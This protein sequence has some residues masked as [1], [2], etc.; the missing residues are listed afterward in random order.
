MSES[1]P[2][3][4]KDSPREDD[5]T[6]AVNPW[7]K[8]V[9]YLLALGLLALFFLPN[10][11]NNDDATD[12]PYQEFRTQVTSGQVEIAQFNNNTGKIS[13]QS[14][15]GD[16]FKTS[17][18]LELSSDDERLFLENIED[19][20]FF[21]PGS[22]IW[23]GFI[24]PVLGP[25]ALILLFFYWLNRRAQGQMG[26]IMSIGRSKAKA[27]TTERP[28]TTFDDVAG[29]QGV[30][31]EIQEVVDF[32]Q[33]SEKFAEIGA[34]IPKGVLLV[35]PPGTGK[36]LIARAVAGE[37]GVP[38]L[39]V[40]GSDFMEMFVGVGAS[41][42]RDLFQ[43]A[44]KMGSAIIF[45]DEIDSIGRKRGAGLGGGHDEREQ[46]LN[47]MLAEMDGFEATEG[48]VMMAATNR[49]DI[50]DPALLRPGRF[51]RQVIVSL[52]ELDDREQILEVHAKAKKMDEDVDLGLLARGTPGMSGAD[53]SNLINEAALI[54]V[55]GGDTRVH[56][57]HLEQA[58]DRVLMGQTRE[59]TVLNSHERERVAYHESGHALAA[60]LMPNADPLHK[61]SIIP[62]GMALGVT[63]TLPEEDRYLL[64]K[65]YV[66]DELVKML[67]G[68]VAED[69]VFGEVS[70]GAADDL[71]RATDMARKMV[72]EWGM[73]ER[74]GPMAW[75]SQE[76]VFLGEDMGRGRDYSDDMAN[77]ID[78]EIESILREA[79][80]RCHDLLNENR[81]GLDALAQSLLVKE[82]LDSN[83][84]HEL[85]GIPKT[86]RDYHKDL[87]PGETN[88]D[89]PALQN[90]SKS[91]N[92]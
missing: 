89:L 39:S 78:E 47:Q 2:P 3:A 8:R 9:S 86:G 72:R 81:E 49:P 20:K 63:M 42:V 30:K 76:Q 18:P 71:A 77:L 35:G 66:K 59:A 26:N 38:F 11:L 82:T 56:N 24:I 57:T 16:K 79:E 25:L 62:R 48:I 50:L 34:R 13:F 75:R 65:S 53:L 80:Q 19:F 5:E 67:G 46:T 87:T 40:P 31:Q 55:R 27:Y 4:P 88:E 84:V 44:R 60:A 68:R 91:E 92:H 32:L 69:I 28:S 14:T 51:D 12:V 22:N 85:L 7:R 21:T 29:Y 90:F 64:Q 61:V 54:A 52:P 33:D 83:D 6:K 15:S 58:R 74:V 43:S 73:S 37:A 1:L 10:I 36:T 70:S 45:I 41:R 17:G 23:T